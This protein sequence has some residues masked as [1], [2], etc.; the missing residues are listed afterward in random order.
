MRRCGGLGE[1]EGCGA[2]REGARVF[3][4]YCNCQVAGNSMYFT[5]PDAIPVEHR[6]RNDP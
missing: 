4:A 6:S 5:R 2:W 1:E 3:G